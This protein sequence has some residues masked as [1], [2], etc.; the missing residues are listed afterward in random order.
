MATGQAPHQRNSKLTSPVY[1]DGITNPFQLLSIQVTQ[2]ITRN[3]YGGGTK[4]YSNM[5]KHECISTF[6]RNMFKLRTNATQ[7]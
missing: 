2:T 7:N 1:T 3:T 6:Q 5:F 4:I